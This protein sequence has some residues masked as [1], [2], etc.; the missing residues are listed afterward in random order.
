LLDSHSLPQ[1]EKMKAAEIEKTIKQY[2]QKCVAIGQNLPLAELRL[3]AQDVF[4]KGSLP[5]ESD[6]IEFTTR[7]LEI[8]RNLLWKTSETEK[9]WMRA[10]L[11]RAGRDHGGRGK[12]TP[13][14]R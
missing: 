13:E 4:P 7:E 1:V 6:P 5:D 3:M 14:V 2:E 12:S 9:R 8:F 11:Q 10:E